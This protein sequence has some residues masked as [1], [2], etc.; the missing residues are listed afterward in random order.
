LHVTRGRSLR[1]LV[2]AFGDAGHAFP[3]IALGRAL[4]ARGHEVTVETW[5]RWR[6][7]VE[8][9]GLGFTAAEEYRVFP[10]PPPDGS[11][12]PGAAEAARSLVP[13]IEEMRPDVVVSDILTQAP[14]LAAEVA[15]R[16]WA[17]L[18]P[19]VYPVQEPG[20]PFFAFGM[21]PARTGLGRAAWRAWDPVLEAG[22]RRGRRELNETRERLGLAPLDRFHGGIS[23][24]LALVATFPQ[25]EYPRRWPEH[26][27]VTG[28]MSFELPYPDIELP[29]GDGPLVVVASSTAQDPEGRLVRVA[30]EALAEEPV[31]VLAAT[32]RQVPAEGF[33]VPGNAVVVDWVRYSQVM[34]EADLVI[35]HGGH[36]TVARALASGAPVLCC[37]A[38][39]DMAE[40]GARIAWSG[41]G[42]MLPRRLLRPGPMRWAARR[43]LSEL[44][45]RERAREI[46][47]WSRSNDGAERGAELVEL[48]AESRPGQDEPARWRRLEL[49]GWESNPRVDTD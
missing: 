42:L 27:R 6:E 14:A 34:P 18:I 1:L 43:I 3:A 37:P 33:E 49:R 12:G 40:N 45:F 38:I 8:G 16:P 32:N 20:L 5:G 25:L 26:V 44:R 29:Q 48:Y 4:A 41:A 9:A 35:T 31:R 2:A 47:A 21:L 7:A 13:M 19:H 28:P 23:E 36:G 30:L 24:G 10:P 11:K 17:T 46:A 15:G 22:L 39:G